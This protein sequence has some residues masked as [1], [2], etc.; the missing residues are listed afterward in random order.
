M[1][2]ET[3]SEGAL[4]QEPS[5]SHTKIDRP[6]GRA[7]QMLPVCLHCLDRIVI[8]LLCPTFDEPYVSL[9]FAAQTNLSI[10]FRLAA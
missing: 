9:G 5:V 8:H 4:L 3:S 7:L 2:P 6:H 10:A 1:A